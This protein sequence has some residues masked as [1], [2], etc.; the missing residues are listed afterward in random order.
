[1]H[2]NGSLWFRWQ[3]QNRDLL[4]LTQPCQQHDLAICK[5]QRIVMRGHL[6]P[7]DL[8]KDRCLVIDDFVA[9]SEQASR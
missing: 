2:F 3:L 1:L 5:F 6:V 9:P 7:V 4:V 8:P